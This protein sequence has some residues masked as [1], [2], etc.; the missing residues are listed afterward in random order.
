MSTWTKSPPEADSVRLVTLADVRSP[1]RHGG[2]VVQAA[3]MAS[4]LLKNPGI[5][6]FS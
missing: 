1:E 6:L 3:A 4:R 5:G 2:T